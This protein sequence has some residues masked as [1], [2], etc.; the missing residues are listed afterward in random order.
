[1]ISKL[2]NIFFLLLFIASVAQYF[3]AFEKL[4]GGGK[5]ISSTGMLGEKTFRAPQMVKMQ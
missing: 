5:I 3:Y 1:M 2:I 4:N